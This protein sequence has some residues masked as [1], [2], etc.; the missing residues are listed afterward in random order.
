[1]SSTLWFLLAL[2]I[3]RLC[4]PLLKSL[5]YPLAFAVAVSVLAPLAPQLDATISLGRA[6]SFLPF[7][8]IG[9]LGTP[10]RLDK[11]RNFRFK[12]L[13]ALVLLAGLVLS[14]LTHKMFP[15]G[16]FHMS[17]SYEIYGTTAVKGI[18]GRILVLV[19]GTTACFALLAITPKLRH[20]WTG[21]GENSL[22]VYLLH[23]PLLLP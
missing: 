5:R 19:V 12:W 10:E 9:L 6:L 13:A 14:F 15:A 16:I 2:F 18:I 23:A 7:F 17:T 3:W 22:T 8:V 11:I 20:W 21:I 1:P 4:T